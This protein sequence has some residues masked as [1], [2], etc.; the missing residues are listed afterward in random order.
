MRN[1]PAELR[2]TS[3]VTCS[4]L[5]GVLLSFDPSCTGV[6]PQRVLQ[7]ETTDH[8]Q[9]TDTAGITSI[10]AAPDASDSAAACTRQK[11]ASPQAYAASA[12]YMS[13][14]RRVGARQSADSN[15][16]PESMVWRVGRE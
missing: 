4:E 2:L 16:L 8:Q 11:A 14:D 9:T 15:R 6:S 5:R 12:A 10:G 7:Q 1:Q 3:P 13:A